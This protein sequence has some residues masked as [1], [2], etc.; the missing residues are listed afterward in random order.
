[1]CR[2]SL[3]SGRPIIDQNGL[4]GLTGLTGTFECL[5]NHA[6]KRATTRCKAT[7]LI[8]TCTPPAQE[9]GVTQMTFQTKFR[10]S[11]LAVFALVFGQTSFADPISG[12]ANTPGSPTLINGI[13]TTSFTCDIFNTGTTTTIN[14]TPY[15]TQGG[16]SLAN[17][18]V[19]AGYLVIINGNPLTISSNNTNVAALFNESLWDTVL[20]FPGDLAGGTAS[21]TLTV[22]WPGSFPSA[23][24]VRTLDETLYSRFGVLDSAFFTQ[25]TLP[26]TSVAGGTYNVNLSTPSA[27]PEPGTLTLLISGIIGLGLV[28]AAK[29]MKQGRAA[30][31]LKIGS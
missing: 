28:A 14:L 17:N 6:K 11:A 22:Y 16:A 4:T 12:C 26:V 1:M 31:H 8:S 7:I 15:L 24:T 9:I 18:N 3:A 27:V 2:Q 10:L 23:S 29:R 5:Q 13:L 21:D 20:Y 25:A 19:A 30:E